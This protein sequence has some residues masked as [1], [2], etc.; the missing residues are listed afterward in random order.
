MVRTFGK[1]L[2]GVVSAAAALGI[3]AY[4]LRDPIATALVARELNGE[5]GVQCTPIEVH[6]DDSLAFATASP[7]RCAVAE[8][9][10]ASW[11]TQTPVRAE[12]DGWAVK[13]VRVARA[14]VDQRDR[15]MAEVESNT[16]GDLAD[17]AGLRD[18]LVKGMIDA[19]ESFMPGGPVM[20]CDRLVMRRAGKVESVL[21]DFHRTFEHGWERTRASRMEGGPEIAQV[22]DYDLRVTRRRAKLTFDVYVGKPERG[23]EPAMQV[24]I[25][26][27][28]LDQKRPYFEM[29]L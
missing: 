18:Q 19:S 1:V 6:I 11:S 23:D 12:L 29:T 3:A 15:D 9:P 7:F 2:V 25:E 4:L 17:L 16:L 8:G 22:R 5:P 13:R 20:R 10:V 27:R 14:T 26:G 24:R 28:G 21:R